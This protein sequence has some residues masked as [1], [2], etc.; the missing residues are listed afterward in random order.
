MQ[1]K[2]AEASE[3]VTEARRQFLD[4]GSVLDAAYCS[5]S[6]GR[7]LHE[8]GKYTKATGALTEARRKFLD[9]GC[10]ADAAECSEILDDTIREQRLSME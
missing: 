8:Q 1:D 2:Y 7:I 10:A 5:Q 9:I 3:I 6:L 4:I